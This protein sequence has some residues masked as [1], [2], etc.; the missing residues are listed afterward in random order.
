MIYDKIAVSGRKKEYKG[1]TTSMICA[2]KAKYFKKVK[3]YERAKF[4]YEKAVKYGSRDPEIHINL[5]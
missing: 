1:T 5:G 4:Q 3:D 2:V